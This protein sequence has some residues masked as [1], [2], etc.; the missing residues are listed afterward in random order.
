MHDRVFTAGTLGFRVGA[1]VWQRAEAAGPQ[2]VRRLH[3]LE[4]LA[5]APLF[6]CHDCGDCS[7]PEI[8][9]LCPQSQCVKNQRNGPC[10]GTRAGKCEVGEKECIWAR[11]YD[12]LKAYGEEESMLDGPPVLKDGALQGTSAWANAF[13]GRDHSASNGRAK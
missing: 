5:K 9:Y 12:R 3:R 8:A 11:A 7:L 4:K 13:L 2:R 1:R 10:G 6:D